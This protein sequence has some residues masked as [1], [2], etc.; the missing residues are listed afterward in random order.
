MYTFRVSQ[1]PDGI[2]QAEIEFAGQPF[3]AATRSGATMALARL[4]CAAGAPNGPWQAVD[5]LTGQRRSYGGSIHRL[6]TLMVTEAD[7]S[8]RIVKYRPHPNVAKEA[9][10]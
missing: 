9:S 5:H 2:D 10:P 8:P 1:R 3:R 7:G 4:L 6:A